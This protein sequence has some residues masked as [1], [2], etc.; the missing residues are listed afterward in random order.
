M[1]PLPEESAE[2]DSL[3]NLVNNGVVLYSVLILFFFTILKFFMKEYKALKKTH[4]YSFVYLS[5]HA[6]FT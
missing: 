4:S 6:L 1:Q 3:T 2:K 5:C